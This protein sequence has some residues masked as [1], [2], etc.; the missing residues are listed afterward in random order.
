MR[1]GALSG[2]VEEM[3]DKAKSLK[4]RCEESD[5]ENTPGKRWMQLN[6]RRGVRRA[7]CPLTRSPSHCSA[8]AA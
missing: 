4:Q 3:L 8:A 7:Q 6:D 2:A 1:I 5:R